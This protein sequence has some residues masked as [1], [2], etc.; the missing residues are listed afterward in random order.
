MNNAVRPKVGTF[1][2]SCLAIQGFGRLPATELAKLK[3]PLR[4]TPAVCST[5][6]IAALVWQS[7]PLLWVL[8]AIGWL[9]A[10]LSRWNPADRFYNWVVRP[11]VGGAELPPTPA[12]RRFSCGIGG[13][14]A[15]A[16]ALAFVAGLPALAYVLGGFMVIASFT[17][18]TTHWCLG[19]WMY[20]RLFG[21]A[22]TLT[23]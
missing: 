22:E 3:W 21:K 8:A 13:T 15:A 4:F 23:T 19:G 12:P 6:M 2:Q 20:N 16:T 11:A 10:A 5:L 17:A 18:A 9:G 1:T 7:L 14:F